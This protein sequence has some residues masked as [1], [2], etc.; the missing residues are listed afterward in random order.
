MQQL[1][2][3]ELFNDTVL[4]NGHTGIAIFD[5]DANRSL[6][7]YQGDKYFV[8]ASN[9]KI[10][11]LYAGL[12]YLGDSL[13]GLGYN[14]TADTVYVTATGDPSFLHPDFLRQPVFDFLKQQ[15]KPVAMTAYNWQSDAWGD[16]WMWNDYS[17]GYMAE[18]SPFPVYGNVIRW[19]QVR[20]SSSISALAHKESFIYSEPDINW[21]VSFSEDTGA[22]KFSAERAFTENKFFIT[23]GK[24][25]YA[26][27]DVPFITNGFVSAMDLLKDSLGK[28]VALTTTTVPS[29]RMI[30]SQPSD[31][32]FRPMMHRSDNFFAEQTLLMASNVKLGVMSDSRMID[33]MLHSDLK[34]LPQK[35]RWADGSGLS[36]YNLFTPRDFVW[37]LQKMK[38]EFGLE[39][40]K[41]IFATGGT[42][43]LANY[44]RKDSTYIYAKTG[45]LSGVICISG[46]LY[47]KTGRLMIFSVLVNNDRQPAWTMR[48]KVEA[49]LEKVRALN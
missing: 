37:I 11:T 41:N 38:N 17:S 28:A 12:K 34:D 27:V 45:S 26:A 30:R 40:L 4:L 39:R 46:Y 25:P 23:Q 3:K 21:K 7:D 1:A 8:P 10:I 2:Q 35:P 19:I 49:F 15:S 9:T 24:E 32:L 18:R 14:E 33:N 29:K 20:D 22:A 43:T 16:G 48:K 13:P 6:Y 44:Y 31:S 5:A 47:G 36:R 42:G